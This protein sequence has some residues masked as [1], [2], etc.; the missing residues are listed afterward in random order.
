MN[1]YLLNI[2]FSQYIEEEKKQ[3]LV[4]NFYIYISCLY[5]KK[6][7]DFLWNSSVCNRCSHLSYDKAWKDSLFLEHGGR[8]GL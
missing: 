6:F 5:E 3:I 1:I 4:K 7:V 8:I 2:F